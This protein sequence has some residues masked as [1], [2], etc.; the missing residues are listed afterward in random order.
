[1][2]LSNKYGRTNH[3]PFSSGSTSDDRI[4]YDDWENMSS[5]REVVHTEKLDGENTCLNKYG[6]FARWAASTHHPWAD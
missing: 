4:N 1:M 2:S 5:I 6:V 3:Y